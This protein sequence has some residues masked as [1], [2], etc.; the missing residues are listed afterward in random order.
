MG[1][2]QFTSSIVIFNVP[3]EGKFVTE[4]VI[5]SPPKIFPYLGLIWELSTGVKAELYVTVPSV[6]VGT[7]EEW[8]IISG[9]QARVG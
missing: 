8:D 7:I 5:S 2:L 1:V 9:V 3:A 6:V 4:N